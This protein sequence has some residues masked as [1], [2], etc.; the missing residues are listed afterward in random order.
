MDV[1]RLADGPDEQHLA[2][3]TLQS[4]AADFH[5]LLSVL[6]GHRREPAEDSDPDLVRARLAAERGLSIGIMLLDQAR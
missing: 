2:T 3:Q 1:Q 6:D 4:V 5:A